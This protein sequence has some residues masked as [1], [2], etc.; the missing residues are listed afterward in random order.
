MKIHTQVPG[1]T[2]F[3]LPEALK[4]K[5]HYGKPVDVFSLACVAL[6]VMSHQWPEPKDLLPE[7]SM[8]ALTEIQRQD[9]YIT[10]CTQPAI[11]KLVELCLHNKPCRAATRNFSCLCEHKVTIEKQIPF[12][13]DNN[14]EFE[15]FDVVR[16]ANMQNQK[17][18]AANKRLIEEKLLLLQEKDQQ[19]RGNKE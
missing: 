18:S 3:M 1:T 14:F 17:L 2:H 8:T 15:L 4:S 19:I 10:L 16:Q 13:T 6:Q 12:S 11:K 7:D 9:E 5:P